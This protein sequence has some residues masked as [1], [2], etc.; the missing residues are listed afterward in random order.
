M[1]RFAIIFAER[2]TLRSPRLVLID[3]KPFDFF[4]QGRA[5]H[6]EKLRGL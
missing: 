4:H 2:L 1:Q 6:V 3:F 5:F